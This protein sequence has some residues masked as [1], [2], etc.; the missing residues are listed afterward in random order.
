M[1][2]WNSEWEDALTKFNSQMV[3][4][5]GRTRVAFY[6]SVGFRHAMIRTQ[7]LV[8]RIL[9]WERNSLAHYTFAKSSNSVAASPPKTSEFRQ[10]A[11]DLKRPDIAAVPKKE[12]E[13]LHNFLVALRMQFKMSEKSVTRAKRTATR[14]ASPAKGGNRRYTRSKNRPGH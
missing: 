9:N 8:F 1:S 4:V 10:I 3:R 13:E 14:R 2:N 11:D 5:T 12:L 7:A 6:G